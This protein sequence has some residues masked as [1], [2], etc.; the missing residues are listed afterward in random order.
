MAL[1]GRRE[2]NKYNRFI[3]ERIIQARKEKGMTQEELAKALH[4]SRMT[5]AN[6]E[7]GRTEI[8][9]VDLMG[10]AY[11]LE[12]PVRYFYPQY[13]PT[14]NDLSSEEWELI[15]YFRRIRNEALE[16]LLIRQAREFAEISDEVAVQQLMKEYKEN[17]IQ[18]TDEKH[19]GKGN[20]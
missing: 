11:I 18:K 3:R 4:R 10:I 16:K 9:A 19:E 12:K 2:E 13:V 6:I 15:H 7:S 1:W 14:E 17:G 5:I 20:E 8:N